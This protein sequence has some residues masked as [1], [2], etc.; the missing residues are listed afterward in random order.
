[1]NPPIHGADPAGIEPFGSR[2]AG[3]V[4]RMGPLCAGIDPSPAL[5]E[6]WGLPDSAGG[7][8]AFGLI[9]V[10]ALAHV[11]A[12]LKPQVAF[13]ER[14]GS[15]GLA[16]LEDVLAQARSSGAL[17]IADAKR[18]DIPST[19]AAYARAWLDDGSPLRADA[20]TVTPY[21]GLGAL[22]PFVTTAHATGRGV[23][24][25]ARGS[26]PEGRGIQTATMRGGAT[27]EDALLAGIAELNG[28]PPDGPRAGVDPEHRRGSVG[29]VVGANLEP[30][31]FDLARLG[32]PILA[33]GIGAQGAT[34]GDLRTRFGSCRPGT[35][36]ANVSRSL[37]GAGPGVGALRDAARQMAEDL[38][39]A[40][41]TTPE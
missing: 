41:P 19:S 26:N 20:V 28:A 23:F 38:A 39:A 22:G 36:L 34:A 9:C 30:S 6:A 13:F 40:L 11:T 33:P 12:A 8:R 35:V 2:L 15:A 17:V 3:R 32:G 37:L 7:V 14:H 5:L 24:V 18:G 29:A 25:V 27:V 4:L 1:V 10:E 31:A 16:A 21:M